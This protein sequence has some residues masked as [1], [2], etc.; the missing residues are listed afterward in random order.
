MI[1]LLAYFMDINAIKANCINSQSI[2]TP[3]ITIFDGLL[4]IFIIFRTLI[5]NI[6]CVV[7][8][9]NCCKSHYRFIYWHY[10]TWIHVRMTSSLT[11]P[12]RLMV[13]STIDVIESNFKDTIGIYRQNKSQ[14]NKNIYCYNIISCA[15]I[16]YI[17][18]VIKDVICTIYLFYSLINLFSIE[19]EALIYPLLL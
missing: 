12:M 6:N 9:Q 15:S 17:S 11:G 5:R 16:N 18:M 3:V 8:V 1:Y 2:F 14:N 10:C 13:Y 7:L 4:D 19:K